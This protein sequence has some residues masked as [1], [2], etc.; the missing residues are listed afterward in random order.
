MAFTVIWYGKQG[1]VAKTPSMRRSP[2]GPSNRDVRRPASGTMESSPS[3]SQGQRLPSFSAVRRRAATRQAELQAQRRHGTSCA[4][5]SDAAVTGGSASAVTSCGSRAEMAGAQVRSPGSDPQA[6]PA[7]RQPVLSST[8][9]QLFV[10]DIDASCDFFTSKLGFAID[11]VY[12]D[13]PF[14]GQVRR[15]NA[16]LALRLVCEPV[17]VGDIRRAR[18][19]ALRLDHRRYRGR[20]QAAVPGFPGRRGALP[21]AAQEAAVGRQEFHRA[22][23]GRKSHPVR[24]SGRLNGGRANQPPRPARDICC[25]STARGLRSD[26]VANTSISET[27]RR[28]STWSDSEMHNA[29]L[30][31]LVALRGQ[32]AVDAVGAHRSLGTTRAA[33][34]ADHVRRHRRRTTARAPRFSTTASS[35][36]RRPTIATK[37]PGGRRMVFWTAVHEMGHAFNLAHSWQ[38]SLGT[39]WIPLANEPEARSFMNYPFNVAGGQS[40]FFADFELPLQ[41]QRVALHAPRAAPLRA[42]GQRRLVRRPRLRERRA[43]FAV[44]RGWKL[45]DSAEPRRHRVRIH[46]TGDPRAEADQRLERTKAVRDI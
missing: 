33:R 45:D 20:D 11:F 25:T 32:A 3:R 1:I 10:A 26:D 35:R 19:S 42:A 28:N 27:G 30:D 46:G 31:L 21:P 5:S 12:G 22:G 36:T 43:R 18:A 8:A 16:Q 37:R 13:P 38:K 40:A 7:A 4:R 39:P 24:R 23:P 29:M 15:D 44:R 34:S 14:Y 6:K 17:F 41:R 9:A 2:Q